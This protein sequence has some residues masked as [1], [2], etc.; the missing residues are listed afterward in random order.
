LYCTNRTGVLSRI[1]HRE[2]GP[3]AFSAGRSVFQRKILRQD[4]FRAMIAT[5]VDLEHPPV[6][7]AL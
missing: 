3:F 7:P 2:I 6:C 5:S 1:G 4:R